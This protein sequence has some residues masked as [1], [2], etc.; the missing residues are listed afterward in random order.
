ME[1]RLLKKIIFL[2]LIFFTII[3]RSQIV[4]VQGIAKDSLNNFIAIS[5]NDTI[6]KFRDKAFKDKNWE[7]YDKLANNKNFVTMPDSLGNYIINAKVTD[8]LY[9]YKRK[10]ITQKYKVEDII[11]NKIV[12]DLKPMPCIPFK[13]CDQRIPSKL[14][15][16]V[17]KKINVESV[18]TSQYCGEMMDSEYKAEY[19]IEQ[20]FSEHYPSSTIIFTAYDHNSMKEYDFRNYNNILVFVGEYCGDLIQLKYQFFPVY[21]TAHGKWAAVIKPRDEHYYKQDKFKPTNIIFDKSVSFDLPDHLSPQQ[22]TQLIEYKFPEKYYK[23][24]GGKVFP[25]MGRSAEDLVKL[26]KELYYKENK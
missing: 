4:T 2:L 16:F 9:F 22:I 12:V 25:I 26:W 17:G 3:C 7:G 1:P 21:K 23:I 14:Y 10:Y 11:K 24:K 19:R 8:T 20:E 5:V 18:D 13:T 6:R 15:V